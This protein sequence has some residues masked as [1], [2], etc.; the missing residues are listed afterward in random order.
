MEHVIDISGGRRESRT[1]IAGGA[2]STEH[3]KAIGT[4]LIIV[5]VIVIIAAIR[6]R[7][8]PPSPFTSGPYNI[9]L[10]DYPYFYPFY[11]GRN[12]TDWDGD[13]RCVSYC[14]TEPCVVWCR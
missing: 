6:R 1:S 8:N 13:K 12:A 10:H 7:K 3:K 9:Q 5:G 11:T 2:L 14:E 4:A